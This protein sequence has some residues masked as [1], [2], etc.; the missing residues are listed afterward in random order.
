MA[1]EKVV[2]ATVGS[3]SFDRL[4]ETVTSKPILRLLER[5]GFTKLLVQIG[6]GRCEPEMYSTKGFSLEFY[7]YKESLQEDM[8]RASLIISHAGTLSK[9]LVEQ[10]VQVL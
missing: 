4:V 3:T 6:R 7:R 2:F 9:T 8:E 10:L 5:Q 1:D